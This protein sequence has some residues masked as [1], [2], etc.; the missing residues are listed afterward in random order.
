MSD[1]HIVAMG[2]GQWPDDPM[3]EYV[4]SLVDRPRPRVCFLTTP[5]GDAPQYVAAFYRAFPS[6]R[7]EP[8]DLPLF[9][10]TV[11]DVSGFL[12][13]QDVVVVSGGNTANAL[14]VWRVH[15]VDVALRGAWEAG[16]VL[17]GAS[18]GANCW[19]EASTTDAFGV[20]R[21]DPLRDGLGFLVGSFCPHYDSEPARRPE[22]QRMISSGELPPGIAC[23]DLAA[24]H[25]VGTEFAEALTTSPEAAVYRVDRDAGRSASEHQLA[26]RLLV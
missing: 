1:R 16:V 5:A 19:F 20:G 4:M 12:V 26:A 9:Q 6:S 17:C 15:G 23:D 13:E 18:A 11:G 8:T 7:F 25:F 22:F 10:R 3:F 21:A 2:G 14:A 24:V